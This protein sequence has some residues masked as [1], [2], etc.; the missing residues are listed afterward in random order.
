MNVLVRPAVKKERRSE[1]NQS[2]GRRRRVALSRLESNSLESKLLIPKS[3]VQRLV[4]AFC[5]KLLAGEEPEE[6]EAISWSD[7]DALKGTTKVSSRVF[8]QR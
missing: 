7:D 1:L 8:E 5:N 3:K 4:S 2:E 6:V